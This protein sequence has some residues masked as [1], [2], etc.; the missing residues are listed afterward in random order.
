VTRHLRWSEVELG[1]LLAAVLTLGCNSDSNA[2]VPLPLVTVTGVS[3][4]SGP[5][6]G[7][8]SVTITGTNFVDVTSVT[9]GG[10]EV[11]NRTVLSATQISGTTPSSISIG[12]KDVV[13]TSSSHSS[14]ICSGCFT[15]TE[16][17]PPPPALDFG[18]VAPG[19]RSH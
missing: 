5:E 10:R 19:K 18:N 3:P 11:G 1:I 8:T 12:P 9:I 14:D 16:A 13:V 7:G 6:T 4:A 17:A 15:Y 2:P